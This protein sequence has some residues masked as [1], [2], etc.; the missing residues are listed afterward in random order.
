MSQQLFR[1]EALEAQHANRLGAICLAQPLRLRVLTLA[2]I[3]I[4]AVVALYLVFGSYTRRAT[5]PGRLVPSQGL[6]TV[7]APAAGVVGELDVTEGSRVVAG[8]TVAVIAVP[9]VTLASGSS[10]AD[11]ESS[12]R[13]RE[14]GL[15]SSGLGQQH[16][17][18]A[19]AEGLRA[20][21]AAARAELAQI[22]AEAGTREQQFRISSE[23]LAR[24]RQL[25]DERYVSPAQIRQQEAAA[26]EQLSQLQA[27]QRDAITAGRNIAQLQQAL[28]QIPGQRQAIEAGLQRDLAML[29]QERAAM[30]ARGAFVITAPV[31]GVV[32]AQIARPGQAVQPGQPLLTVLPGEGKLEAE[33]LVPSRAIG[34][35]TPGD[36]VLLRY[37]AYPYQK[38]GHQ[39]GTVTQVSRSALGP[40]ELGAL[41]GAAGGGEPLYRVTVALARQQVMAYGK[42]E[43]LKPGMLLDA[44]VLGERRRL[45]EWLFEPLYSL[46]GK[47]RDG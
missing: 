43:L 40:G 22:Q 42:P 45:V 14:E 2:A 27:L 15:Q 37:Q 30:Q 38:F 3:A 18:A 24:M 8:Q 34:F 10:S 39:P 11:M 21:L 41:L 28:D 20:Q 25:G 26:L 35:I 4:A 7:L 19:Q 9:R 12:L 13:R 5:V 47:L 29:A 31:D 6:A 46:H 1:R 44:D 32:A 17:L 23:T 16:L 36:K 33:L